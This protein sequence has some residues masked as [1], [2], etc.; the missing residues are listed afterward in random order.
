MLPYVVC[1]LEFC[2]Y[3]ARV[4]LARLEPRSRGLVLLAQSSTAGVPAAQGLSARFSGL[5]V[6]PTDVNH[7][8]CPWITAGLPGPSG[9]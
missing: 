3:D 4:D 7:W 2:D 1:R 5:L 9:K 6:S 8:R